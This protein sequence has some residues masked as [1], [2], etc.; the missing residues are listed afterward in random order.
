MGGGSDAIRIRMR[1]KGHYFLPGEESQVMG[2]EV[3]FGVYRRIRVRGAAISSQGSGSTIRH[4]MQRYSTQ[5]LKD[6]IIRNEYSRR[7]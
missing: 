6:S 7:S 4:F 2:E 3:R 1:E 5:S